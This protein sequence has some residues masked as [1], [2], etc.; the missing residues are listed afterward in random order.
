MET[1]DSGETTQ[2]QESH[3]SNIVPVGHAVETLVPGEM[4]PKG[5]AGTQ[6]LGEG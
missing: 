4:K 1:D 2:N 5:R 6:E 3:D